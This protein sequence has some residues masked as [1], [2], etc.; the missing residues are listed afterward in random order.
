MM[1]KLGAMAALAAAA[2]LL[3][4]C[5]QDNDGSPTA[6]DNEA[7]NQISEE[8]DASPDSL[9]AEEAALGNGEAAATG[10]LPVVA[11]EVANGQ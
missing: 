8:L 1:R 3:A 9:V 5:G 6:A 2:S 7:L 11:N 4:A 10:E